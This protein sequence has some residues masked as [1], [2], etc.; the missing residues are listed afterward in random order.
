MAHVAQGIRPGG[1]IYIVGM[2][3]EDSRSSPVAAVMDNLI[4]LNIYDGGQSYTETQFRGWL[5]DA[6]FEDIT[7]RWTSLPAGLSVVSTRRR[8]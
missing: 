1:A 7:V 8:G 3:L 5:T 6:G 4:M 2:V